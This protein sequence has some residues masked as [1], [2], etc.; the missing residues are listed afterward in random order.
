M[1]LQYKTCDTAGDIPAYICDA[2]GEGE[3]GSVRGAAYINKSLKSALIDTNLKDIQWWGTQINAGLIFVVPKTRG[4]FDGG[5]KKATSAVW[6]GRT[7]E[8][9]L[10]KTYV[11]NVTDRNHTENKDFYEALQNNAKNF[12]PAFITGGELR[13]ARE[14]ITAI[15]IKDPVEEAPDSQVTWQA[16]ITW[17]QEVPNTMVPIYPLTDELKELFLNCIDEEAA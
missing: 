17:E 7:E 14:P 2:C 4:T 12:I 6:G 9:V 1:A 5:T 15:E 13:V 16:A 10:G 11:L 8:N 3:F